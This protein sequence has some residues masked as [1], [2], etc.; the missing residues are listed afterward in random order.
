MTAPEPVDRSMAT[1]RE[2]LR[3]LAET[4]ERMASEIAL[5]RSRLDRSESLLEAIAN[6]LAV[7]AS[8]DRPQPVT[9][10][11]LAPVLAGL[12]RHLEN[13]ARPAGNGP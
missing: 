4:M 2:E 3:L 10:D 8:R 9:K 13:Q 5:L 7:L 6:R 11:D 12:L 1:E